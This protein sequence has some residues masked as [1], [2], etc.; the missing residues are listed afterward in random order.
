MSF[1]REQAP[2]YF[3]DQWK[4]KTKK[5]VLALKQ[6]AKD[7]NTTD[8]YIISCPSPSSRPPHLVR[9]GSK[10]LRGMSLYFTLAPVVKE[11]MH[12]PRSSWP[13][14]KFT[15]Q[16]AS[17]LTIV[18]RNTTGLNTTRPR[19]RKRPQTQKQNTRPLGLGA[20]MQSHVSQSI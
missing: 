3:R 7:T 12:R 13:N 10:R 1:R 11:N 18:D 17:P 5:T 8:I 19:A 20:S 2:S 9:S 14:R 15:L 16:F 6:E 4:I